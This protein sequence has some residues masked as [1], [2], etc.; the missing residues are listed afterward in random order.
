MATA[1]D[2][3]L[4]TKRAEYVKLVVRRM[5]DAQK[6]RIQSDLRMQRLVRD[7]IVLKEE[8]EKTFARAFELEANTEKEYERIIWREIKDLPI[9]KDW[10]SRVRGIGKRL[11][12]LLVA[13]ILDIS[14]FATAGK[15]WAYAGLHVKDGKAVKR[16]KGEK[17]N[18][19]AELKT[20]C[21]KIAQ[22]F[23]KAGGPYREL[24]DNYKKYLV[25]RE[26][27]N[28]SI[29][30]KSDG[31]GKVEV[32][33]APK[34]V[35]I[36]DIEIPKRPEWTLGR[37]NNMALRRTVKLFLSNLW[38]VWREME[39]LEVRPPYAIEKL[40]HENVIDPWKMIEP[41]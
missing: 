37:I 3:T 39:G 13:N 4:D 20:T 1:V 34:L 38:E 16:A 23:V 36:D 2:E 25:A 30:W 40:G 15:L 31:S 29:I 11:S 26:L 14:R 6:L 27:R 12:G 32:A 21:W 17:A 9:I 35:I 8:A 33:Y 22:S 18:W 19:N 28:G 10:L 5:Y 24:Y 7:G 41:E